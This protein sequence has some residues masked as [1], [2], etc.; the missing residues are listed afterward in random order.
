MNAN[1]T[2]WHENERL[3]A[4]AQTSL[5]RLVLWTAAILLLAWHESNLLMLV[6]FTLVMF[7]PARKRFLLSLAAFGIPGSVA[8]RP[9]ADHNK[10]IS[11]AF[12]A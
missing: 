11:R 8:V 2:Q 5:G 3:V 6:A 10:T 12:T 7:Y 1:F 9:V 4:V